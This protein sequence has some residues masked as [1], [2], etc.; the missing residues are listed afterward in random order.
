MEPSVRDQYRV[1]AE[2]CTRRAELNAD[3]DVK[4]EWEK[5]AKSWQV[6]AE[7]AEKA[8]EIIPLTSQ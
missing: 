3:T 7:N 6:L 8:F 4:T 5:L 2:E 1:I